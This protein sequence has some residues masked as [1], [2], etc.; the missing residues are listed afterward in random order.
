MLPHSHDIYKLSQTA[1]HSRCIESNAMG[2]IKELVKEAISS[3]LFEDACTKQ[4]IGN[5]LIQSKQD[6]HFS[7]V[8]TETCQHINNLFYTPD[9]TQLEQ[10]ADNPHFMWHDIQF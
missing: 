4:R 10:R 5:V 8:Y 1:S 2:N 3:Q 7:G 6:Y 9:Y